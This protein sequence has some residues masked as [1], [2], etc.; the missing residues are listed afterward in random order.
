[1]KVLIMSDIHGNKEALKAVMNKAAQ[2]KDIKA[3]ILLGDMIDYG[4]HS[5]EVIQMVKSLPY[6]IIC[7]ICGNH[8]DAVLKDEYSR[9]SSER[10]RN[11]ARYTK[12]ILNQESWDYIHKEMRGCGYHEFEFDGKK[13]LAVHGSLEDRHWKSIKPEQKLQEYIEYDY[14][15]SGHSHLPHFIEKYYDC[16]DVQHRNKKKVIFINPGS[17]G[18]PRNLNNMAQFVLLDLKEELVS[19]EKVYYNIC[20]EQASYNGQTDVF[21]C[22]RLKWGI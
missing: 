2:K 14:V 11:S 4:M 12:S 22:E 18:Q 6:P 13:C 10:G 15:F 17:V 7:N 5:N 19:F 16:D 21:Y 8:E 9:F 3:C 20:V 1:M